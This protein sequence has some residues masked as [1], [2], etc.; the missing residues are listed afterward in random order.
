MSRNLAA[1]GTTTPTQNHLLAALPAADYERLLPHLEPL[2]MPLGQALYESG[3]AQG[4]VYFATTSIVSLLHGTHDK[5][6]AEIAIVGND[7][8]VGHAL[9]MGGETP[10]RTAQWCRARATAIGSKGTR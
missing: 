4:Y 6:S 8:V 7:G 9:F 1:S 5:S 2:A 3:S 10:P